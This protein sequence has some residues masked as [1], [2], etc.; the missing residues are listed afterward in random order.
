MR[1]V[2]VIL[3]AV[4]SRL[5]AARER[6]PYGKQRLSIK[7][8][9][10]RKRG[11][12]ALAILVSLVT[13]GATLAGARSTSAHAKLILRT[14]E[15]G[16]V[17]FASNGNVVYM[18]GRDK[19]AKSTCYGVCAKA[20][21]PLLTKSAPSV[22]HGLA[23]SR[24]GTTKRKDGSLQVT[25]NRHPLYFYTGDKHGKIMCQ[26][27]V[28]HGGIWLVLKANGTPSMAKGSMHM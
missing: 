12:Y 11:V 28:V 20:W 26:H 1:L 10:S 13:A 17:I 23:A 21:P 9:R 27:A 22:G 25:Y 8:L 2:L 24:L 15:F 14:S 7:G 6:S 16:K 19:T 3:R 4:G 18:F 5:V